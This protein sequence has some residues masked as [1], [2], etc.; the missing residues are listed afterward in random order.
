MGLFNNRFSKKCINTPTELEVSSSTKT[1]YIGE[2]E[3]IANVV[4]TGLEKENYSGM[5]RQLSAI[6]QKEEKDIYVF[7]HPGVIKEYYAIALIVGLSL[8]FTYYLFIGAGTVY[9]SSTAELGTIGMFFIVVSSVILLVNIVLVPKIVSAI[10]FKSRFDI[11]EELLG[12]KSWEFI[13]D[14][15]ICAKQPEALVIKDLERAIKCKLIPQGHL[16]KENKVFMVSNEVYERYM[17]KPAVYDRYFQ[18]MIEERHRIKSRTRRISLIMETGERYIEKI[19]GYETLVKDKNISKKIARMEHIVSM[20]FHE[21]DANPSQA[22]SLSVFLNYYLPTTEKLLDTYVT[23][24]EKQTSG[25][26]ATQTKREIEEAINTIVSAFEGIL[27]KLYEEYE[28]DITSDI[29]AI[30]LSMKQEGLSI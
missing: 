13:D 5:N 11:Y 24:D 16:S 28:M 19:H 9:L 21:I 6:K 14:I 4:K 7:E 10:R 17:E 15:A 30:E 23:M 29:A 25:K 8:C 12:Y 26:N 2:A 22:Q 3:K 1:G 18:K 20:I 27:E